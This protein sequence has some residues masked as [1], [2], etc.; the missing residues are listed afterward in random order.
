MKIL[1]ALLLLIPSLSWGSEKIIYCYE[2]ESTFNLNESENLMNQI[3]DNRNFKNASDIRYFL[4]D[5]KK[6]KITHFK[7]YIEYKS[8]YSDNEY[9]N[10]HYY[11]EP[12]VD[13]KI[14]IFNKNEIYI[15]KSY[16]NNEGVTYE[17]DYEFD[18]VTGIMLYTYGIRVDENGKRYTEDWD[19]KEKYY[20]SES[21]SDFLINASYR[22]YI[23]ETHKGI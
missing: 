21:S 5:D 6:K 13:F 14:N 1:L 3:L 20:E 16:L 8:Q 12:E 22:K 11:D 15:T 19:T 18:R 23:C 17:A 9:Y 4:I 10:F 2:Y 7:S